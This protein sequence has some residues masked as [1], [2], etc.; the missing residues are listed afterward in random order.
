V[1]SKSEF[2]HFTII[3]DGVVAGQLR[4]GFTCDPG[5]AF[6]GMQVWAR[7][8]DHANRIV[9]AF[10]QEIGFEIPGDILIYKE[11]TPKRSPRKHPFFYDIFFKP[12]KK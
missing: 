3:A 10:G 7:S 11:T 1:G 2:L 12:Y 5:P 4:H 9:R 6:M 8:T